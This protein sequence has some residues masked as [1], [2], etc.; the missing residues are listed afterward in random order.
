MLIPINLVGSNQYRDEKLIKVL[1][2]E[3]EGSALDVIP[4]LI[5]TPLKL[6]SCQR[7]DRRKRKSWRVGGVLWNDAFWTGVHGYHINKLTEAVVI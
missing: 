7:R 3:T 4:P 6:K 1:K 5:L 2:E